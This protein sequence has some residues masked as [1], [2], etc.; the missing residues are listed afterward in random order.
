MTGIYAKFVCNFFS[1]CQDICSLA[2]NN[3]IKDAIF[4]SFLWCESVTL[5][6]NL[7]LQPMITYLCT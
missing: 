6:S 3:M 5:K 1:L 2:F 7:A 4:Q